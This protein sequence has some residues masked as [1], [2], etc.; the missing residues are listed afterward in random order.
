MVVGK[1]RVRRCVR[2]S[3]RI[4]LC[5]L[6]TA[7]FTVLIYVSRQC[8]R[9]LAF[10]QFVIPTGSM[11]PTLIPGD[12]VLVDKT[13]LGARLYTSLDFP[14]GGG[15]LECV[16]LR[17][18]RRVRR[19]DILVFNFPHHGGRIS[20]VINNVYCKRCVALPGDTLWTEH[21]FYRN[22]NHGGVLGVEEE[23]RR[24]SMTPDSLLPR[25]ILATYPYDP[26]LPYTT[27]DMQR[28]Y[29]PRRGDVVEL[30]PRMAAYYRMPLEWETGCRVTWDSGT[31]GVYA[32][33][34]PLRSHTFL[35]DYYFMAGDNVMDSSDS[36][37][38]GL[39]PGEYIVGVVTRITYS[40]DRQTGRLRKE[41]TWKNV[42]AGGDGTVIMEQ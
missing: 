40:R 11:S 29:I 6:L 37:N 36:R 28:T 4:A 19:N 12:R 16:R 13:I 20:F 10:D 2:A 33:G 42:A 27:K 25:E 1:S 31:G 23:Q 39:V 38:W 34:K 41:R 18:R 24:F 7:A 5:V 30:T 35:H 32:D 14:P 21:G 3:Y 9:A 26:G 17:G 15:E 22:S 8:V